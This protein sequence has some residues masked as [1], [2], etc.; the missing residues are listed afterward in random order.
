MRQK[1]V[2]F[3]QKIPEKAFVKMHNIKAKRKNLITHEKKV[4]K[5]KTFEEYIALNLLVAQVLNI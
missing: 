2:K 1:F 4:D 3:M 5:K